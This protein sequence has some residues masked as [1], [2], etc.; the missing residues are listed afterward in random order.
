MRG[1]LFLRRIIVVA[2][3]SL[4]HQSCRI[5]YLCSKGYFKQRLVDVECQRIL[6]GSHMNYETN[7]LQA[8]PIDPAWPDFS[9][10]DPYDIA[11]CLH[12]PFE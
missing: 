10:N 3:P 2:K 7:I 4:L 12:Y 6:R 5:G 11:V 1:I 9:D 8:W